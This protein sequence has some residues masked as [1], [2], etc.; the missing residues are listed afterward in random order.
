[1][2]KPRDS[3]KDLHSFIG[4]NVKKD[5][6]LLNSINSKVKI[7]FYSLVS[8]FIAIGTMYVYLEQYVGGMI[9]YGFT[10]LPILLYRRY[11]RRARR[12]KDRLDV[13]EE[14]IEDI[15][16]ELYNTSDDEKLT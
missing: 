3:L 13:T 7:L 14:R 12:L 1:M 6:R 11:S 2:R 9:L 10:L 4:K 5:K 16:K 8:Y 15:G